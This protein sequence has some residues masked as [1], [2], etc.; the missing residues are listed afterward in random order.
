MPYLTLGFP[1]LDVSLQLVEAAVANGA[2]MIELGVPFS[3]PLADGPVIQHAAQVALEAG[4]TVNACL[5][6]VRTLR[7]RGIAIPLMLMGYYN[8]IAAFGER[9]FAQACSEAGVDGLIIPDLPPEEGSTLEALCESRGVGLTYLLAP[10]SSPQR[11]QLVTSRSRGFVYLVSVAGVTGARDQVPPLLA[12]FVLRVRAMT[13]KPLGVGFGISSTKQAH[14]VA[15][16]ADGVIVGS[17]IVALAGTSDGV[18]RVGQFVSDLSQAV[19]RAPGAP[20]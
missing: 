3:D 17:A 10:T 14:E 6:A 8:P 4:V 5:E 18:A 20:S 1:T 2:D 15:S 16:L 11:M 7:A 13:H 12:E 9:A 19:S